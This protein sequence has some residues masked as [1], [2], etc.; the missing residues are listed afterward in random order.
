MFPVKEKINDINLKIETIF[1]NY[2]NFDND[3]KV[4]RYKNYLLK[5]RHGNLPSYCFFT[6]D[7]VRTQKRSEKLWWLMD[8]L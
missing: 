3:E 5:S 8:F 6:S 2:N 4:A 7:D 1:K